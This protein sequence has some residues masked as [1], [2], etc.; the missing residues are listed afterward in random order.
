MH[1]LL[2]KLWKK[3]QMPDVIIGR[4]PKIY[5]EPRGTEIDKWLKRAI[6]FK[7]DVKR[8]CILDDDADMWPDQI[9]NFVQ[10]NSSYGITFQEF[11]KAVKI[12]GLDESMQE[13]EKKKW[14]EMIK[15]D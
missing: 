10:C 13:N 5:G 9:P 6:D 4:T 8:Y 3:R 11:K 14:Q 15:L 1:K 7:H 2:K 12:L